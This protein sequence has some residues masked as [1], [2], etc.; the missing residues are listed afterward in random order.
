[1]HNTNK[2][3][4]NPTKKLQQGSSFYATLVRRGVW[5]QLSRRGFQREVTRGI[6]AAIQAHHHRLL[7]P[8]LL[9]PASEMTKNE[10][11]SDTG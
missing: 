9:Q 10:H 7:F 2:G 6:E 5:V 1:M 11:V 8:K 4:E 3:E